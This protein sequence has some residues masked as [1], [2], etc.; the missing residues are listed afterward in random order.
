MFFANPS[1][2]CGS[3]GA[4]A[5]LRA[6]TATGPC[7]HFQS[8]LAEGD[9]HFAYYRGA[10][11]YMCSDSQPVTY[12]AALFQVPL[13][14]TFSFMSVQNVEAVTLLLMKH[15]RIP[16]PTSVLSLSVSFF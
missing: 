11:V 9:W 13:V 8:L 14:G 10:P 6:P 16:F 1:S 12:G 4:K 2:V 15:S 7:C 5:V 3:E